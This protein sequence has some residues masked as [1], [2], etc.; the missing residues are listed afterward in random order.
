MRV[1][2]ATLLVAASLLQWAGACAQTAGAAQRSGFDTM[3]P[4]IQAMQRDDQQNPGMLWVADGEALWNKPVGA[5]ATCAHCHGD[6][7]TSMR[8]VAARY[9]DWDTID[10]KP[11]DLAQRINLCRTRHQQAPPLPPESAEL[12]GFEAYVAHQS[13]GMPLVPSSAR[14]L[15]APRARG[16]QLWDQRVGQLNLS[17]ALCHDQLPGRLLAGSAIPQGHV[18]GYPTYRLEWQGMGSLQRRIRNCLSGV[19]AEPPPFN[20]TE[21]VELELYLAQR[22]AGMKVEAPAVRP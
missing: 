4:R 19:R 21:M 12:L 16:R 7:R 13:R 20:A 2:G 18:N 3:S 9:P 8:G 15:D 14:E 6:A 1:R 22:S 5:S 17:C 11:V 10:K